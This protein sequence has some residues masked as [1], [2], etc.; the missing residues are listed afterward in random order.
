M[1]GGKGEG[2][3]F[4]RDTCRKVAGC[5][6]SCPTGQTIRGKNVGPGRLLSG[7]KKTG[8]PFRGNHS[9][10]E[11]TRGGRRWLKKKRAITPRARGKEGAGEKARTAHIVKVALLSKEEKRTVKKVSVNIQINVS[12]RV[13]IR[14]SQSRCKE[15]VK[16]G[17]SF[18]RGGQECEQ[19]ASASSIIA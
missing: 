16:R 14:E 9:K 4:W 18:R 13:Q 5:C 2:G 19:T 15:A 1:G 17:K 6:P 7:K 3:Q 10:G 12:R 11:E 8:Q